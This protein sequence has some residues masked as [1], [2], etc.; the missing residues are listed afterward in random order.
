MHRV[1]LRLL[2]AAIKPYG[3]AAKLG[4]K[5][6]AA[7]REPIRGLAPLLANVPSARLFEETLKLFLSGHAVAS[8]ERLEAHGL[9]HWNDEPR[10]EA[11][12]RQ[13]RQATAQRNPETELQLRADASVPYGR[14]VQLIGM[15]QNAG[16]SRIGFVADA[17]APGAR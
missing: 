8:F 17:P 12:L 9:L 14:V 1:K 11:A 7:T 13:R 16:L 3:L 4:L 2:I 6:D 15:A 5:I 10:A